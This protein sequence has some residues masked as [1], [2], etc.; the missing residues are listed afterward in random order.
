ME[1]G[2]ERKRDEPAMLYPLDLLLTN[3]IST[4]HLA[5][6]ESGTTRVYA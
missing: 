3:G 2:R 4:S 5:E 6:E 1:R